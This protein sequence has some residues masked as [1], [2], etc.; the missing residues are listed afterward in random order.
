MRA[1]FK[2]RTCKPQRKTK[3]EAQKEGQRLRST[4]RGQREEK[5]HRVAGKEKSQREQSEILEMQ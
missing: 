2:S 1:H 4:G 3:V 5:A